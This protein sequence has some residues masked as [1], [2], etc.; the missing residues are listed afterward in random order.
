M[1]RESLLPIP[2]ISYKDSSILFNLFDD[3]VWLTVLSEPA[4]CIAQTAITMQP[5]G[6]GK[7]LFTAISNDL[8]SHLRDENDAAKKTN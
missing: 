5:L 3:L 7:Y 4:C 8:Q 1:A 6:E 2:S